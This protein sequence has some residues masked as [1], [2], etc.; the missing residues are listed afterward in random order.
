MPLDPTISLHAGE[1]VAPMQGP[2]LGMLGQFAVIQNQLNQNRLFQQ[3]FAARQRWGDILAA[4]PDMDT[5]LQNGL[6]D[7]V[8]APFMPQIANMVR[9]TD[10]TMLQMQG[11]QMKQAKTGLEAI[12]GI[13]RAVYNSPTNS[14]WQTAA[15]VATQGLSPSAKA[16]VGPALESIRMGLMD[17]IEGAPDPVGRMRQNIG[18]LMLQSNMTPDSIRAVT[19]QLAPQLMTPG[20]YGPGGATMQPQTG[21]PAVPLVGGS[22]T[23][24]GSLTGNL[25]PSSGAPAVGGTPVGPSQ[26]STAYHSKIADQF[27]QYENDLYDR[28]NTG[29]TF[30]RNMDEIVDAAHQAHIGGGASTYMKLGQALQA[31]GVNNPTVDAWSNGSLAASQVV[32]K[33]SLTNVMN[34]LK[35]QLT[36]IG[37]SRINQQEFVAQLNKNPSITTD[38]RAM[39]QVFNLW[40]DFYKR[41]QTELQALDKAKDRPNFDPSRWP[42]EWQRS[43]FM[44][45]FAPTTEISGQGVLGMPQANYRFEGGKLVPVEPPAAVPAGG[46]K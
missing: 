30:R 36:G 29:A 9:Q 15:S 27:A 26:V 42:A 40:N 34:Q 8:A 35:Q 17:G 10:L 33:A 3:T 39:V 44:Q 12:P 31:I 43:P 38:P 19:G 14:T 2:N 1:G 46:T 20:P 4:S 13:L 22:T 16:A 6:H 7:P 37:G 24:A 21:G 5:A 18:A 32:D 45:N 23:T 11:E 28:V 25:P 41:D